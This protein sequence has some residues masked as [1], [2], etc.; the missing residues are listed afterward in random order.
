MPKSRVGK[1]LHDNVGYRDGPPYDRVS[2]IPMWFLIVD[3]RNV[4]S[5][6]KQVAAWNEYFPKYRYLADSLLREI[7]K[8]GN[9]Y[10]TNYISADDCDRIVRTGLSSS[11]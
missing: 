2:H 4:H 7:G 11:T 5:V 9:R 1:E 3:A 10:G 8:R 6:G